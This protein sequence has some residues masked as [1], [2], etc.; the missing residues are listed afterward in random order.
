MGHKEKKG[1]RRWAVTARL[2]REE[3]G[4]FS[5]GHPKLPG[6]YTENEG[7]APHG[8]QEGEHLQQQAG[9]KGHKQVLV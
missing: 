6:V 2:K 3:D 9:L 1:F 4:R 8:M 7:Q 5:R